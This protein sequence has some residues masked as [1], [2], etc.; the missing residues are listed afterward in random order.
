MTDR[1]PLREAALNTDREL[2]RET[3]GDYYAPSIHVT[4]QGG[5]GITVSGDT[6]VRSIREWHALSRTPPLSSPEQIADLIDKVILKARCFEAACRLDPK[7][8]QFAQRQLQE[9]RDAAIAALFVDEG[10]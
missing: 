4:E 6:A 1:T 2:W 8:W 5:I 9:A 7:D 10:K 3:E